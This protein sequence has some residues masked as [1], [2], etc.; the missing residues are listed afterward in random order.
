MTNSASSRR[1]T[2]EDRDAVVRTVCEAFVHD[3]AWAY[4]TDGNYDTVSPLFAGAL[5]DSRIHRGSIWVTDDCSAT[6]LWELRSQAAANDD[7]DVMR[8]HI[9]PTYR[10]TVGE[11][12]WNRLQTYDDALHGHAEA[13]PPPY[14]YL[15]VLATRP[16]M[17]GR[18]LAQAVLAP[19]FAIA[20]RDGLDC[21]LETSNVGNLVFY[22]HRGF[23]DR[24]E[25]D[26]PEGPTT[27]WMRRPPSQASTPTQH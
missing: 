3:P 11:S 17:Q 26:V 10:Q 7:N 4:L 21:W 14:W 15:G 12:L 20:D 19:V 9:W 6:A 13:P 24:I 25:V 18:G 2:V 27:W 22:L 16:L 23:I 1:A 5:V 8:D